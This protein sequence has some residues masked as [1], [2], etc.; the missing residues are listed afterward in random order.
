M[1]LTAGW[2]GFRTFR[3]QRKSFEDVSRSV[4][5]LYLVP[6]DGGTLPDFRPGQF[7]V[8]RF[9]I[10]DPATRQSRS[11][12]RCYSLS[13]QPGLDYYRVS[14]KRMPPPAGSVGLPPGLA[15]NY[16]H[17]KVRVGSLL[18]VKAASGQFVLGAGE[19][20]IV[21]IAGG[22]GITPLLSMLYANFA[23]AP[24]REM[25]LFYGV[26]NSAEQVEKAQLEALAKAEPH[27]HLHVC[28]SQPLPGDLPGRDFQDAGH[29]GVALLRRYLSLQQCQF[30]VCGPRSMLESI[31]PA[32]DAEGVPEERIHFEAFGPA[33][34]VR[35]ARHSASAGEVPLPPPVRDEI[36]VTFS[37]SGKSLLW[38]EN[39][40]SLLAFAEANGIDVA[41]WC[42]A[43][44]CG[45]CETGIRDGEVTYFQ[46][47]DFVP[48]AGNC[49][50]C[51]AKPKGNLSLLL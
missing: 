35:P 23:A 22:I 36:T 41:S 32:L 47:P 46:S 6:A 14:V 9:E 4:C 25:W 3:V 40:D 21:L 51:I 45:T 42:R 39:A 48:E 38:D 8:F 16:L 10:T 11:V 17:D 37:R 28:Y 27:L 20:T 31:V 18:Q 15:S 7:L 34:L 50:L 44:S 1:E 30:Y 49:L 13:S 19:Q 24:S 26:R 33:S 12:L 2:E 5:S 43:G 29:V